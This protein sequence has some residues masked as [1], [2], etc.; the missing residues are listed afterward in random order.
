ML[1]ARSA[2]TATLDSAIL[3][4]FFGVFDE[5]GL[6]EKGSGDDEVSSGR[7][8]GLRYLFIVS[9]MGVCSASPAGEMES[10]RL[11]AIVR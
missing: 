10:S 8:G 9:E 1:A 11:A 7:G 5:G 2:T 3:S 6:R 4:V